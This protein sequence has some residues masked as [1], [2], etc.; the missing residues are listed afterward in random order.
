EMYN[1]VALI[2]DG[3]IL[4][5]YRKMH[6]PVEENHYFVPGDATTVVACRAGRVGLTI[7]YDIVFP[8]SARLAALQGAELLCVPSNWLA[9]QDLQR[10]GEVL[11]VARALEQQMHVVFVNGVG[12]LEVRGRRWNLYG[13]S[14]IVS[15][16]GHP[17][18]RAA[19]GEETLTGFLPAAA[20]GEA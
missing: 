18:A 14:M 12:E 8:E 11:P 7:C 9:I 4:G 13:G 6:L 20:L 15:A 19:G 5:V 10:L 17:V 1:A 16:T 3:A 2:Q